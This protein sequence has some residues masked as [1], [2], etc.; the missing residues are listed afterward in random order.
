[1][2]D[3][4]KRFLFLGLEELVGL[5]G[6]SVFLGLPSE[7]YF[8]LSH[9]WVFFYETMYGVIGNWYYQVVL[10]AGSMVSCS[11]NQELAR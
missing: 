9:P 8:P 4:T 10:S 5:G 6:P 3:S 11:R 7:L 2:A 1:M